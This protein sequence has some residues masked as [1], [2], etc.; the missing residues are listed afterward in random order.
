[1]SKKE[2]TKI[3]IADSS[4]EIKDRTLFEKIKALQSLP[5]EIVYD[6][7]NCKGV[8]NSTNYKIKFSSHAE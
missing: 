6:F 2:T 5:D 1:M 7:L 8:L 4:N 3:V